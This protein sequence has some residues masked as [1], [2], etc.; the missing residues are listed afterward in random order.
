MVLK[1]ETLASKLADNY[2]SGLEKARSRLRALDPFAERMAVR[3]QTLLETIERNQLDP[4]LDW[5]LTF[6]GDRRGEQQQRLG[7]TATVSELTADERQIHRS[8]YVSALSFG[9][10]SAG[11]LFFPPLRL[12]SLPGIVYGSWQTYQRAYHSLVEK[13]TI[14][15][16]VF[17]AFVNTAYIVGGY[18]VLGSL[19]NTSYFFSLKLLGS[20]KDRFARDLESALMQ[21]PFQVWTV[22]DGQE[23]QRPLDA[24]AVGD[25]VIVHAGELIP[26]DGIVMAGA[27]TV[28]Q[29]VLTGEARPVEKSVGNTVLAAT[30]VLTGT[31]RIT[32]E[33]TG[34][35]TTVG[36]L[37]Q[38]L[39]QTVDFRSGRQLF[40]QRL[41][42]YLI[43]PFTGLAAITWPW[44]GF[45]AA[46]AVIDAHPHRH[47]NILGGLSLL[48]Y[49][50]VAAEQGILIKDGG[51]LEMLSQVDTLIFDK[52]GTL[53]QEQPQILA[54]HL[55]A[56]LCKR[57]LYDED[58]VLA[59]AAAAEAHQS[60]PIARAIIAEAAARRLLIPTA[61]DTEH[62]ASYH[63]GFGVRVNVGGRNVHVGSGRFMTQEGIAIPPEI[64]YLQETSQRQG[65]SLTMVALDGHL[66]GVIELQTVL[67]SEVKAV[68]AELRQSPRLRSVVIISGDQPAP[69]RRLAQE[70]GADEY[71]AEV[72]PASKAELVAQLQKAGRK[73][74]F[75]GDGINDAVALKQANVSI[76]L[77]GAATAATDTAHIVLMEESLQQL[78][79]LFAM[80][81][82]FDST[83]R[84]TMVA[85]LGAGALGLVGIYTL[86]FDL[87]HMTVLD[88]VSFAVGTGVAMQ[89][90][91]AALQQSQRDQ[92][93]PTDDGAVV[94]AKAG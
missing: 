29:H 75:I 47:L 34:I 46:A 49:L 18:W 28:D 60:H 11:A 57:T 41:T 76:S 40:V 21:H 77:Q 9:L 12:F 44:L 79:P 93:T 62:D 3:T 16:T 91:F 63:A 14:D 35:E 48:N 26:V 92:A 32:L 67:R 83:T 65:H 27:A 61:G 58:E 88:Q 82:A 52:T 50:V 64:T 85:I 78:L 23:V 45:S 70:I 31:L 6:W 54:I 38:I 43:L 90:R 56:T 74:C 1:M 53:T 51:S 13:R 73:V 4:L 81:R 19:G 20:I 15:I 39:A 66:A 10:A 71:Y 22:I 36:K 55:P 8:L 33:R 24:L 37:S 17:T 2:R 87:R 42:D 5:A 72:L 7:G 94:I 25:T 68:L 69:T 89:P 80:A 84:Q 59:Y 30:I 86:G